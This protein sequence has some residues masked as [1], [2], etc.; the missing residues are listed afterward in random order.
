[1]ALPKGPLREFLAKRSPEILPFGH[2]G[3]P[4]VM[5]V[6][7]LEKQIQD[8]IDA[9]N[10][11]RQLSQASAIKDV[12]LVGEMLR[13]IAEDEKK[14]QGMLRDLIRAVEK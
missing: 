12:T 7:E 2:P 13:S 9:E 3:S 1:M 4:I 5:W 14:H 10:L 11:Y 8:E 6:T